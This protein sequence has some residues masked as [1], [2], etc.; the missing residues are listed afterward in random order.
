MVDALDAVPEQV[1]REQARAELFDAMRRIEDE[2]G[3]DI[4]QIH[5]LL[6]MTPAERLA[7]M[8]DVVNRMRA[9]T[10]HAQQAGS[11]AEAS[12]P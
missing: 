5:E 12:G 8:V 4:A 1:H 6:A 2:R 7:R 11:R 3:V 9:M 10:D